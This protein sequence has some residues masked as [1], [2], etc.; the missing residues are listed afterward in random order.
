MKAAAKA[1]KE[2]KNGYGYDLI[3]YTVYAFLYLPILIVIIYS[4]NKSEINVNFTGFTLDWYKELFSK[5]RDLWQAL[6]TSLLLA[7]YSTI[8]SCVI[9]TFATIAMHRYRFP[10]KQ[11][12][13]NLLY[14]PIVIPEIV[15]GI[16]F[17]ATMSMFGINMS[18]TTLV[19]SHVTFCV[20][21][22]IF[23]LRP[24]ISGFD[25]SIE[26]AAMDL[27]ANQW[28]TLKRVTIPMLVPGIIAS[29]LM[30]FTLSIDDVTI[31][32][33]AAGPENTTLPIKIYGMVR[34]KISPDVYG[35]C[36]IIMLGTIALVAAAMLILSAN[37]RR[38]KRIQSN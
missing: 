19:I 2:K 26:E 30:S 13:E 10:G 4:F 34:G 20:P 22:V 7:S 16:A 24:R 21:F 38:T 17:L 37:A 5:D 23:T 33:F 9:G 35:Q 15:I 14:I 6:K 12:I 31:S 18:M 36:V 25:A 29:A 11:I 1:G 32:F 28:H 8:I 3:A 27:G